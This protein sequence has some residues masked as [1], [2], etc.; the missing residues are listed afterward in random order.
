MFMY[1]CGAPPVV[2]GVQHQVSCSITHPPVLIWASVLL[3][4]ELAFLKELSWFL[5]LYSCIG[6]RLQM[7]LAIPSAYGGPV[8][9]TL[10]VSW[11]SSVPHACIVNALTAEHI[12]PTWHLTFH[13]FCLLSSFLQPNTNAQS[14]SLC[15]FF[16][17]LWNLCIRKIFILPVLYLCVK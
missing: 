3:I 1:L 13:C 11:A 5:G 7:C 6:L 14:K 16:L 9:W 10:V 8:D 12:A 15:T 17:V 2:A 4:S